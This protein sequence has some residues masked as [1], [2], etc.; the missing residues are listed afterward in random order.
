MKKTAVSILCTA[1]AAVAFAAADEARTYAV[2]TARPE[3]RTIA[4]TLVK[5]GSLIAPT[6]VLLCPRVSGRLTSTELASGAI[7]E[8]GVR[9]RAGDMVARI[10]DREF[11]IARDSASAAVAA[12]RA[13]ADEANAEFERT[14]RLR[15]SNV[16]SE[17]DF[18]SARF[19]RDRAAAA[20]AEAEAAL[21]RAELDLE[22]T[23]IRAPF[24]GVIAERRLHRGAMAS[25]SSVIFRIVATN[26]LHAI[27]ELPSTALPHLKPGSTRVTMTADAYPGEPVE[28]RVDMV[29][30]AADPVTRTVPVRALIDNPG[31]RY[32]PGMFVKGEFAL[33]ER[34][35]VL[36]IPFEAV[37]R[38]RD[39]QCVYRVVDGRAVLTDIV[40]GL[41]HDAVIEVQSGLSAD[42]EIVVGGLH[43]LTDGVQVNVVGR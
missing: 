37:L 43:R 28:A 24:D 26:P 20:L 7:A 21:A 42:D 36:T 25:T 40:T 22:E 38:I 30:P 8:E 1:I 32:I 33:D 3:F 17:Q 11:R 15:E 29:Y 27:F 4:Q 12:A 31:G 18:D 2:R 5:T 39:R 35:N 19:A 9:V 13:S 41:R 16:A 6:E 23:T 10:D 14:S 34:E